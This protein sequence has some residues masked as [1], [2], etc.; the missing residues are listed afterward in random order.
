M[1]VFSFLTWTPLGLLLALSVSWDTENAA[2]LDKQ[3]SVEGK[4]LHHLPGESH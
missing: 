1:G 3:K 4:D 2:G